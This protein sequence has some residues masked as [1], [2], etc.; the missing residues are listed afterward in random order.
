[1]CGEV[2]LGVAA[3]L[4]ALLQ[5]DEG[6]EPVKVQSA[7]I[8]ARESRAAAAHCHRELPVDYRKKRGR[9]QSRRCPQK[10]PIQRKEPQIEEKN[11]RKLSRRPARLTD[12]GQN[13]RGGP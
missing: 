8:L 11:L 5:L 10:E 4:G 9:D 7:I 1:M 6:Q 13:P 3:V 2:E 12:T